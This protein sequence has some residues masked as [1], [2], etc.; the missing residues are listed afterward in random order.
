MGGKALHTKGNHMSVLRSRRRRAVLGSISV[1]AGS[2]ASVTG[3]AP[4]AHASA[5]SVWD[6]VA[7]CESSGN[8]HINTH[9]GYFGGLQ[10][11]PATWV[12]YGG[13]DYAPRADQ[14]T[15]A[16]QIEV[17]RR[18]LAS[19][20]PGAWPVCGKRAHLTK[21]DGGATTAPLPRIGPVI[22][23]SPTSPAVHT[24]P[25]RGATPSPAAH[26]RPRHTSYQV[27]PGD[28]LSGIAQQ[29][30]VRGGWEA[31]WQLNRSQVP[32]P[33][34]IFIGQMLRVS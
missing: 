10:F 19:Q 15:R 2:A 17:A 8:W 31:L 1:L 4:A 3:V 11:W 33:N 12:G 16:Q 26:A 7:S 5:P 18:V 22:H 27:Q 6:N 32:N 23:A 9:N 25:R 20:G 30:G 29:L 28:T 13:R 21:K 24:A 34:V 14:A